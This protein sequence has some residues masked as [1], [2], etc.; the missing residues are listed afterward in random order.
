M[1]NLTSNCQESLID[2]QNNINYFIFFGCLPEFEG[3]TP[4][5]DP[6]DLPA[7]TWRKEGRLRKKQT[8]NNR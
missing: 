8:R 1:E 4:L 2:L 7:H 3:K 5:S 6:T